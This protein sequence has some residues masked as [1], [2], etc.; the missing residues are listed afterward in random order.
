MFGA[1]AGALSAAAAGKYAQL[2]TWGG[3]LAVMAAYRT[4]MRNGRRPAN[5]ALVKSAAAG[6]ALSTAVAAAS[7]VV[8]GALAAGG[9]SLQAAAAAC[10]LWAEAAGAGA[11]A[12]AAG[13]FAACLAEPLFVRAGLRVPFFKTGAALAALALAAG[14]F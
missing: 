11:A 6:A 13:R 7:A 12:S 3:G 14:L 4:A 2:W 9:P 10:R 1:G 5:Y 8:Y